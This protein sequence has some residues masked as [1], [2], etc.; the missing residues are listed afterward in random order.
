VLLAVSPELR[1]RL[2]LSAATAAEVDAPRSMLP[3]RVVERS[4]A[5]RADDY[6]NSVRSHLAVGI[7]VEP[8]ETVWVPKLGGT[9]RYRPLQALPIEERVVFRAL[10][11]DLGS[12]APPPDRSGSAFEAFQHSPIGAGHEYVVVT[13]VVSFYFFIDHELLEMRLIDRTARADTA[14]G[15]RTLLSALVGRPYGLPQNYPPSDLLSEVFIS[16]VHRRLLRANVA[17]YRQ[18]DDFR[19]GAADWGG[20]LQALE[21]LLDELSTVGLDL[22]SEKT[23]IMRSDTYEANLGLSDRLFDKAVEDLESDEGQGFGN[24]D[25]YT[26]EP[27]EPEDGEI[28]LSD[29]EL[30]TMSE[31]V[32]ATAAEQRL[33]GTRLSGFELRANR[34]LLTTAVLH[35][36]RLRSHAAVELGARLVAVDPSYAQLHA[37]YLDSLAADDGAEETSERILAVL[38]QF[39]G[40]GPYWAQAWLMEPLLGPT[41]TLSGGAQ[42]WLVGFLGS[43]APGV[44]RARAALVLA[45]H[46]QIDTTELLAL[47]DQL[48]VAARPDLVAGLAFR[49]GQ[50]SDET[51]AV[52]ETGHLYRWVFD[53]AL[54]HAE[55]CRWA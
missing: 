55:D 54:A 23:W 53:Y 37:A 24:V 32:F 40:H 4:L 28:A 12:D 26:G 11:S 21:L 36:R 13:D 1:D 6:A 30:L 19:L 49:T 15:L 27:I 46:G 18:N 51:Q 43:R 52:T 42:E 3:S 29:E 16:W 41:V 39:R 50:A 20:A 9:G 22:N 45:R 2:E 31:A 14:E 38:E 35:F 7:D 47:F 8:Q 33:S 34:E 44:L 48:P 5:G 25:P 17:T 10:T